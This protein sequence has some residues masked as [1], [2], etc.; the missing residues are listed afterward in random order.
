MAVVDLTEFNKSLRAL[1]KEI[2]VSI[3]P[4][5]FAAATVIEGHAK[6]NVPVEFGFLRGSSYVQR[7]TKGAETGF[8]EEYALYVHENM[9]QTL[10]GQP[11]PS[12]LGTYWNPGGPKYLERAVNENADEIHRIFEA[13]IAK[14][15]GQ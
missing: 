15:L 9:E 3:V 10:E 14:A 8:T 6:D 12:G 1:S 7:I 11:R 4:A 2:D 5:A 13:Y